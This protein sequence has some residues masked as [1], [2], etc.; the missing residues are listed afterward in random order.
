MGIWGLNFC[1]K[2]P[3]VQYNATL[4]LLLQ[5]IISMLFSALPVTIHSGRAGVLPT[6]LDL[7]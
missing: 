6:G 4:S 7:I 1:F 3:E 2:K 5:C